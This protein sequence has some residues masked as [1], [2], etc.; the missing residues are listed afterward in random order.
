MNSYKK[1]LHEIK[2][3]KAQVEALKSEIESKG[4]VFFVSS[5]WLGFNTTTYGV[6]IDGQ[7]IKTSETTS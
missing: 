4:N 5:K 6:V 7:I 2:E 1:R 3:L